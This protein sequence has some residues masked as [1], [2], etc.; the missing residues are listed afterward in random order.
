[1]R[2]VGAIAL[3]AGAVLTIVPP[4]GSLVGP[5]L[6][7]LG[8]VLLAEGRERARARAALARRDRRGGYLHDR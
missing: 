3:A 5:G 7:L 1:M 8:V 4:F 2:A 6:V